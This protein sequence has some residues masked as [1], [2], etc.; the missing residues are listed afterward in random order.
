[1]PADAFRLFLVA[2]GT[3]H[4][5]DLGKLASVPEDLRKMAGFFGRLGYR[6]QL[7]E[8]RLDPTSTALRTALSEWLNGSDRQASDTAVIYYSGHGDRQADA[9]YLITSD[10]KEDQYGGVQTSV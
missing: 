4:Y 6:E 8:V 1:V 5:Q 3:E 10:T 9:F 2:A 7:L